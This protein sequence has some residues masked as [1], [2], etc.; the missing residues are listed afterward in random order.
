MCP[1]CRSHLGWHYMAD[2]SK[3]LVPRVFYGLTMKSITSIKN[4]LQ[5]GSRNFR[6]IN[7]NERMVTF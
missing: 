1:N 7:D 5:P 2:V 6:L 4:Y 3:T